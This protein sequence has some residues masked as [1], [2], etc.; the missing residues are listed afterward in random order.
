MT[1]ILE[2]ICIAKPQRKWG[3][4]HPQM[5]KKHGG[6][7]STAFNAA[8]I[9]AEK[10]ALSCASEVRAGKQKQPMDGFNLIQLDLTS[11]NRLP[12]NNYACVIV[13]VY[14]YICVYI[15]LY[16][17]VKIYKYIYNIIYI[18]NYIDI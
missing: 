6:H 14:T 18:N 13:Y 10:V 8:W 7:F 2:T 11:P 12:R 4:G 16:R 5:R 9:A 1:G 3:D 17:T 15:E